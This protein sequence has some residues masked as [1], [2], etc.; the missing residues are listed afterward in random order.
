M[1]KERIGTILNISF[2]T[3]VLVGLIVY[4]ITV[5]GVANIT[6]VLKEVDYSWVSIGL[7][8]TIIY[9]A[10]EGLCFYV[11]SK[12]LY[13]KQT[14]SSSFRL[15]MIGRLFNNITP[16]SCGDQPAQLVA[17][18]KEGKS[19]SN[20]ASIL[21][22]RFIVYQIV[23]VVYTLIIMAFQYSYFKDLVS[24]FMYFAIIGF[25]I[26]ALVVVFLILLA[27]NENLVF[28][29]VKFFIILL[30]KIRIVKKVDE[31]IN[32]FR[33]VVAD[34]RKQLGIIKKEKSMI[35]QMAIYT[36]IE[37]T[38]LYAITYAVYRALGHNTADFITI[39]SAQTLLN[40]VTV[41]MPTPGAGLAAE[42][43]FYAVFKTFFSANTLNM[44]ILFWRIYTFYLP[45]IVGAIFLLQKP[46]KIADD[47]VEDKV[48]SEVLE[49]GR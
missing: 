35:I 9:W 16:M 24:N 14:F 21:L 22:T 18:K 1:K 7:V 13:A 31:N 46:Q 10:L 42:G 25:G 3:L 11:V 28:N 12:K 4:M 17:M 33:D 41:Y 2:V 48:V 36:A 19:I 23:L 43:G 15:A 47:V 38:V 37:I 6:N 30:G 49:E 27:I 39:I 20:G 45:I 40:L 8:L 26:N 34:F 44:G 5:D 29:M 32:K